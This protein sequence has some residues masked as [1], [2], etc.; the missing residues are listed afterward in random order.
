M[1]LCGVV[2]VWHDGVV[3]VVVWEWCY[4]KWYGM[5]S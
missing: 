5:T 2:V 4:V 3:V 1:V